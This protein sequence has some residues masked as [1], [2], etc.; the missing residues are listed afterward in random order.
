M[1]VRVAA[2][3]SSSHRSIAELG[4]PYC[5]DA[6]SL[7][8]VV[9]SI[10]REPIFADHRSTTLGRS[11]GRAD[12]DVME[13][14]NEIMLFILSRFSRSAEGHLRLTKASILVQPVSSPV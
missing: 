11:T 4:R 12:F 14:P 6:C 2:S 8:V 5:A 9:S 13:L 1:R 7:F 10:N 3:Q